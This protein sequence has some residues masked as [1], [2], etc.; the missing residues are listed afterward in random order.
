MA[1][2]TLSAAKY[3][4][5]YCEYDITELDSSD[6][7]Q[8]ASAQ[9]ETTFRSRMGGDLLQAVEADSAIRDDVV[10]GAGVANAFKNET[11]GTI[12]ISAWIEIYWDSV[13]ALEDNQRGMCVD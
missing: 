7:A 13:D 5:S 9:Q 11:K 10:A 3:R 12:D 1:H 2:L 8:I 4:T 6:F